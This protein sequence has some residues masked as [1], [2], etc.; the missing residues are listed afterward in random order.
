MFPRT[1][2]VTVLETGTL[3]FTENEFA[4]DGEGFAVPIAAP[5]AL[6]TSRRS[7]IVA[8]SAVERLSKMVFTFTP[9]VAPV[10]SVKEPRRALLVP[11]IIVWLP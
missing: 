10:E 5:V 7:V 3:R 1:L 2:I 8:D 4:V 9:S 6:F 11:A